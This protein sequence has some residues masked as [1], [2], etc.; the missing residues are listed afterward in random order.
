M[1]TV[2][3]VFKVLVP[4]PE[5]GALP[6]DY[7]YAEPGH[8]DFPLTLNR[9]FDRNCLPIVLDDQRLR[10]VLPSRVDNTPQRPTL[11]VLR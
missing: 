5:L 6:G 9:H 11:K 2:R 7:L 3:A 8:P 4:I 10:Q 1:R